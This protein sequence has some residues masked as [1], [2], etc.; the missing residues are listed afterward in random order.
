MPSKS[1]VCALIGGVF[2]V[3]TGGDEGLIRY[4]QF[5]EATQTFSIRG[6]FEGHTRAITFL[7]LL[8]EYSSCEYI[9][10]L[11]TIRNLNE[12]RLA[13]ILSFALGDTVL[14]ASADHTICCW[15]LTSGLR[16]L[17]FHSAG[18][19]Q[20]EVNCLESLT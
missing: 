19:H 9:K 6:V 2:T 17:K 20:A 16:T 12:H 13:P 10:L 14:S 15:S 7:L 11:Y 4:W 5:E 1:F 3:V 8:G 18:M